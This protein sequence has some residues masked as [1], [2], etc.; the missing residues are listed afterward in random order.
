MNTNELAENGMMEDSNITN[1]RW[2]QR[3]NYIKNK[4]VAGSYNNN[5]V[6]RASVDDEMMIVYPLYYL[7]RT[8]RSIAR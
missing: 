3:I 6:N 4:F 5:H 2:Y 8:H 1:K 7:A